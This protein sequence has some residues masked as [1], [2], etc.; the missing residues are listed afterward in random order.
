MTGP[1]QIPATL[2]A[3]LDRIAELKAQ[4]HAAALALCSTLR[5]PGQ[6]AP[7]VEAVAAERARLQREIDA[8]VRRAAVAAAAAGFEDAEFAPLLG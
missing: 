6:S 8:M 3:Q 1:R 4:H 7:S 2:Q 5:P